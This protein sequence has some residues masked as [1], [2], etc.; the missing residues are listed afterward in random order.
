VSHPTTIRHTVWDG[1]RR[2]YRDFRRLVATS[3][4]HG[5]QAVVVSASLPAVREAIGARYFAPNWEFSYHERGEDLN[6]AR[7]EYDRRELHGH[8][9]V[10]WQTHVRGWKQGEDAVRLRAHWELEPTEYDQDHINGV[11][12]SVS[13]GVENLQAALDEAGLPY[14][15]HEDLPP[16][17]SG[18]HH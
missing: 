10:W 3:T 1:L 14:E 12:T 13:R 9:Y 5:G 11:G 17:G 7:I 2:F 8:E 4:E 16:G 18:G 15:H 6:L